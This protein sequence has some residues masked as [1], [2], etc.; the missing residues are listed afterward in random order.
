M[1]K[2]EINCVVCGKKT[3][4]ALDISIISTIHGR[5]RIIYGWKAIR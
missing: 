2:G 5:E 4:K 1:A 3:E